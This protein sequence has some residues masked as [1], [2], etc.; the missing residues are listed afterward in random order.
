MLQVL[1][2]KLGLPTLYL[3]TNICCDILS[4]VILRLLM[5]LNNPLTMNLLKTN[6]VYKFFFISNSIKMQTKYFFLTTVVTTILLISLL[7]EKSTAQSFSVSTSGVL[8]DSSAMLDIIST[9]KG[10]LVPRVSLTSTT[11]TT[12]I[13]NPATSLMVYNT[14]DTITNGSGLGYYYYNGTHW[15]NFLNGITS[16]NN[17]S[18]WSPIGN[19]GTTAGTNFIGTTDSVPLVL[20]SHNIQGIKLHPK[21]QIEAGDANSNLFL[22]LN[23]GLHNT[24]GTYNTANGNQALDSNTTGAYNAASGN[25]ALFSNTTGSWNT[26]MGHQALYSNTTG[27]WNTAFGD[28]A[29]LSET[30][31]N[32][33]TA[34]GDYAGVYL[35]TG[36]SCV[37]VGNNAYIEDTEIGAGSGAITSSIALG[38]GSR[39]T[40]SYQLVIG[41]THD[42]L[43]LRNGYI[44]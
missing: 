16:G 20:K 18:Y 13:A 24:T 1:K 39:I 34:I 37:F 23:S 33:N 14:N 3:K 26:A 10:L 31:G 22:G 41:S 11:D 44:G 19:A 7:S 38:S 35:T 2:I 12:T 36:N 15:V 42:T 21:G 29:L 28:M 6:I 9:N 25:Q 40:N 32:N 27:V 17:A 4:S 8:P 30:T 43:G 5:K